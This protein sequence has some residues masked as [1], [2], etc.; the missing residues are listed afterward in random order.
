MAGSKQAIVSC[1]VSVLSNYPVKKAFLFGSYAR[2]DYTDESDV[3]ILLEFTEPIGLRYGS[4]YTDLKEVLQKEPG[5]MTL[6][7]LD[8]R[9]AQFAENVKSSLEVIYES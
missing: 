7:G 3:D 1:I 4:L 8:E 5:L 9:S 6:K 2:N